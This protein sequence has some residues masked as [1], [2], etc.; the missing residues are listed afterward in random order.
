MTKSQS[1]IHHATI[2]KSGRSFFFT[3]RQEFITHNLNARDLRIIDIGSGAGN[4]YHRYASEASDY[5]ACD[6]SSEIMDQGG[7][8]RASQYLCTEHGLPSNVLENKYDIIFMIGVTAYLTPEQLNDYYRQ[9]SL[10]SKQGTIVIISYTLD[11]KLRQVYNSFLRFV[12]SFYTL[13][14]TNVS[15][16]PFDLLYTTRSAALNP[17]KSLIPFETFDHNL[18]CSPLD[19]ILSFQQVNIIDTVLRFLLPPSIRKLISSDL[20]VKYYYVE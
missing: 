16:L 10:I 3:Q 5:L 9:I 17:S 6:I 18:L 2:K 1:L 20:V 13:M 11:N 12:A 19:R 4:L 7:I 14:G 8:P 15:S